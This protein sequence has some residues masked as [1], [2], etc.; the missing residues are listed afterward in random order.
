MSNGFV[1][2]QFGRTEAPTEVNDVAPTGSVQAPQLTTKAVGGTQRMTGTGPVAT[3]GYASANQADGVNGAEG[4]LGTARSSFGGPIAVADLKPSDRLTINGMEVSVEV[5]EKTS[6]ITK[7]K[8][9]H[10]VEAAKEVA[11]AEKAALPEGEGP[12]GLDET[13]EAL[14][15]GAVKD[16]SAT[17]Q[18]STIMQAINTG[19]LSGATLE[20]FASEL[21][22]TPDAAHARAVRIVEGFQSQADA[23][24]TK[25]GAV[26]VSEVYEWARQNKPGELKAAMQQHALGRTTSQYA[27]LYQSFVESMADHSPAAIAGASEVNG[28]SIYQRDGKT[29]VK[30]DGQPEM[31]WRTAVRLNLVKI[32]KARAK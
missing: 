24:L 16:V 10:Y 8:D 14:W 3:D 4:I 7:D 23:A 29:I 30:I 21:G 6:L 28:G 27:P 19:D 25:L 18:M 1:S 22:V 2:Y 17:T 15:N 26:D 5:A 31:E 9:G 13:A 20:H 12:Q 32:S 11:P